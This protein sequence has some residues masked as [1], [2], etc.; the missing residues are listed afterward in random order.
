VSRP[1][2]RGTDHGQRGQALVEFSFGII[3]FLV[4][5]VGTIDL[6]RAVF[7]FNGVSQAARELARETSVYPGDGITL[8]TSTETGEVFEVQ[9]G[10]V[11]GL[12]TPTYAC[13]DLAGVLQFDRCRAGDWVRV[14]VTT[15]YQPSLPFLTMLGPLSFS[16]TSS[17]EIQ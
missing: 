1:G 6:A 13:Y 7:L 10:L 16:S 3:I 8:G 5:F 11:P 9:S 15:T 12:Q 17:A 2:R 4:L 14:S